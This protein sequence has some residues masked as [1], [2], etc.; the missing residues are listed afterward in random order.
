MS[1]KEM[2]YSIIDQLGEEELQ[3]FITLF[4]RLYPPKENLEN[5]KQEHDEMAER[6]AAFERMK[7][8]CRYIPNLDE[9]QELAAYREEKYGN[10]SAD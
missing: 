4:R 1:T 6:R 2:A 7:N 10:E 9:K 8:A 3:C 5:G